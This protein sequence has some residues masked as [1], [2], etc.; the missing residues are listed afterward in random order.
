MEFLIEHAG[1]SA[2]AEAVSVSMR[3]IV[4][5]WQVLN[6]KIRDCCF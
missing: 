4:L 6:V 3:Y 2:V 1:N 5:D